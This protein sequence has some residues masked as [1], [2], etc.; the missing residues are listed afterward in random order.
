MNP[1]IERTPTGIPGLDALLQGG[2]IKNSIV[3]IAGHP[4]AGKTTLGATFI[5]NGATKYNE[6][7]VYLSFCESKNDFFTY[8]KNFGMD[9]ERLEKGGKVKYIDALVVTKL[10]DVNEV[11]RLFFENILEMN[12]KRVV[13]DSLSA[14]TNLMTPSEARS[15]I[16][17]TLTKMLKNLGVTAIL[18]ADLPYGEVK[19]GHGI[20]EF[21]T[22]VVIILHSRIVDERLERYLEIRKMR[23]TRLEQSI[24]PYI[25]REK[26]FEV[27]APLSPEL[28]GSFKY[29]MYTTGVSELDKMLGGGLAKS[30][31]S[32]IVGPAGSGK[33][34]LALNIALKNAMDKRKVLFLSLNES[35]EQVYKRIT[36]MGYNIHEVEPFL[37]VCA[38]NPF[39]YPMYVLLSKFRELL[40]QLKPD[41]YI[42]D[43]LERLM[44][45][46]GQKCFVEYVSKRVFELKA[47]EITTIITMSAN[48][49]EDK[50][51]IDDVVDNLIVLKIYYD[52]ES[53]EKYL[54]IWKSRIMPYPPYPA[55]MEI[56]EKGKIK[57]TTKQE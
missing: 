47:S 16:T 18:I 55:K 36:S 51:Y 13:I 4:G 38:I 43:S 52:K 46:L 53:V 2:F 42:V 28:Q 12:A 39:G 35:K 56:L 23:G 7:G 11:I 10:A 26:G 14:I 9:F 8:M 24:V 32:L 54:Y 31:I 37:H 34:L 48:Y 29:E 19:I 27:I 1:Q 6:K 33:S 57:L 15:L 45:A 22:D 40:N 30:S 5:Y 50:I 25:I 41:L 44:F 21:I 17:N 20:E 49:P 3:L